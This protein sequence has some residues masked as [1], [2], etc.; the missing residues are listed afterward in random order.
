MAAPTEFY[1]SLGSNIS[2]ESHL[3]AAVRLLREYGEVPAISTVWESHAVGSDG[4]NF[5]NASIRFDAELSARTLKRTLIDNIEQDLGRI[6]SSDK[7]AAR[8]IDLDIL[9]ENGRALNP[10]LWEHPFVILPMAELLPDFRHPGSGRSL[11]AEAALAA[12][13]LWIRPRPEIDLA[14]P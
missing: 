12:A 6:R 14:G 4:P 7:N 1:L 2:P 5:L 13:A 3:R 8:T 10:R 9:M 11:R